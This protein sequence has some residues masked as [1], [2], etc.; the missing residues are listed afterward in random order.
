MPM[1]LLRRRPRAR[2]IPGFG[3][4]MGYTLTYLGIVVLLPLAAL[5]LKSATMGWGPFWAVVSHPRTTAAYR[6]SIAA[7][8]VAA[9][10]TVAVGLL[11]TWVL[12]RYSFPG[13]RIVD[14]AIDLPFA[15]PTAVAGIA[16]LTLYSER[17]WLGRLL[18]RP[19]FAYPW[20]EWQGFGDGGW[21]PVGLAWYD[22]VASA[23]LGVVIALAFVGLPFVVRTVQPV[24][25]DMGRDA[26]EAAA[27][28]GATRWQTFYRVILP[29]LRTA[30]LT[31]FGLSFARGLGEYG[32]VMFIAGRSESTN[33]VP[34]E[35][36]AMTQ[37]H[38]YEAA[39]AV[40][41]GLLVLSFGIL[42]GINL[43]QRLSARR[44]GEA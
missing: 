7:S 25:E 19:G 11:V 1:N 5:V 15:L 10:L 8:L 30:L 14:A 16:L 39:T 43:L 21:W 44:G 33:I 36:I 27:S 40:A 31:G 34:L 9:V 23:P 37:M 20:V 29:Q 26:E 3:L 24:L 17:G 35:I 2:V 13:R 18:G 42:M 38:Q 4:S 28:L 22:T 32:S 6:F 41:V 12:V